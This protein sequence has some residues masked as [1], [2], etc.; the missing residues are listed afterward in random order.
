MSLMC[1]TTPVKNLCYAKSILPLYSSQL[2][3]KGSFNTNKTW[4]QLGYCLNFSM[5]YP[6]LENRR[7]NLRH[8]K[9]YNASINEVNFKYLRAK[10]R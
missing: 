7:Y 8:N 3:M 6:D 2:F 4:F 5:K 10:Y 9:N 1:M